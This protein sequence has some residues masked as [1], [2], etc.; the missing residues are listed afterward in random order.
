MVKMHGCITWPIAAGAAATA[1]QLLVRCMAG[2]QQTAHPE[3]LVRKAC[4]PLTVHARLSV[5][6]VASQQL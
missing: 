4:G 1:E 5:W 2:K 6:Q 3:T